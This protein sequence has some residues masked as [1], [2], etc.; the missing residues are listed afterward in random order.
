MRDRLN[1]MAVTEA[2]PDFLGFVFYPG[3]PR[4]VGRDID[5][6]RLREAAGEMVTVGVFVNESPEHMV[7]VA[8]SYGLNLL[9][10]HGAEPVSSC[11]ALKN[12]GFGVIKAFGLDESF[13]FG[14][15]TPFIP[16][17]DYM[18][19]DTQ[20]KHHGGAGKKFNWDVLSRYT[21]DTPF[22]LS[23]GIAPGDAG[24]IREITHPAFYGVDI[25]SRFETAPGIKNIKQVTSFIKAVKIKET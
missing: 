19:F 3:S 8:R 1:I 18:L 12:A 15:L 17:C 6:V 9:Q 4:F 5:P 21:F 10:L 24:A 22:F 2:G 7:D 14:K 16:V 11:E 23:G 13:D 20:S 25:N